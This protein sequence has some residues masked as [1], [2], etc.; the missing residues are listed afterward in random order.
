M[1]RHQHR[2]TR[3][4]RKTYGLQV[5]PSPH[6]RF[7]LP[8]IPNPP[9]LTSEVK[10][11][12]RRRE[13]FRLSLFEWCLLLGEVEELIQSVPETA[14]DWVIASSGPANESR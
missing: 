12:P 3:A 2:L 9:Q 10:A 14:A 6:P 4:R 11:D 5:H 7:H 13:A 1:N 8:E